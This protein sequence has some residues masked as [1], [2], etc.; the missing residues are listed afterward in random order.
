MKASVREQP[1]TPRGVIA[2]LVAGFEHVNARYVLI[3]LPLALDVFLWL[4]PFVSIR[5]LMADFSLL[6]G[7]AMREAQ[8][9][10]DLSEAQMAQLRATQEGLRAYDPNVLGQLS[11]PFVGVPSL[12][13]ARLGPETVWPRLAD[14]PLSDPMPMLAL[15]LML[16]TLGIGLGTAYLSLIA[17]Q[18]RDGRL[19]WGRLARDVWG[20]ALQ[21]GMLM[22]GLV[23][24]VAAL[25]VPTLLMLAVLGA[26]AP[27]L[28]YVLFLIALVAGF[29]LFIFFAFS[30]HGIVLA[31]R[32]LF[33][34]VWDSL[35]LVGRNYTATLSLFAASLLINNG[36]GILW[37]IPANTDVTLTVGILGHA[38]VNTALVAAT[39]VFYHDRLPAL[40]PE[41]T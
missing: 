28:T 31:R 24:L 29:W 8:R 41:K 20:D 26:V 5:P 22:L 34:A 33:V 37:H 13:A 25:G 30:V 11:V 7:Q 15:T 16:V 10:S 17:Q 27:T 32:N 38:L 1:A 2:S 14:I 3:L 39:F 19:D 35:R 6:F 18:V 12:L 23:A 9:Q 36:L 4:G 40:Y 21:V